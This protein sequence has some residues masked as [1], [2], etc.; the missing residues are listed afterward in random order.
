MHQAIG[1]ATRASCHNVYSGTALTINNEIAATGY[2]GAPSAI[3]NQ[4]ILHYNN[5]FCKIRPLW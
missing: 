4:F 3:K 1:L 2:N 5:I